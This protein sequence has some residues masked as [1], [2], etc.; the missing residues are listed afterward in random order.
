MLIKVKGETPTLPEQEDRDTNLVDASKDLNPNPGEVDKDMIS[1]EEQ[2]VKICVE[3]KKDVN[4]VEEEEDAKKNPGQE[5]RE[6]G[7]EE[8]SSHET[9][10]V[11]DVQPNEGVGDKDERSSSQTLS[12]YGDTQ[13]SYFNPPLNILDISL[14]D[15]EE[16]VDAMGEWTQHIGALDVR[17]D[18]LEERFEEAGNKMEALE[19]RCE[20]V[21]NSMKAIEKTEAYVEKVVAAL[22]GQDKE[23]GNKT[24]AYVEKVGEDSHE[25]EKK[26]EK[27]GKGVKRTDHTLDDNLSTTMTKC[28]KQK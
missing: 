6:I 26:G 14:N 18:A 25:D 2:D 4:S 27:K 16:L 20:E 22:E 10:V 9:P 5:D 1:G 24:E 8:R 3:E 13:L 23:L 7:S 11:D 12:N 21:G 28:K 15:L 17:V 19:D